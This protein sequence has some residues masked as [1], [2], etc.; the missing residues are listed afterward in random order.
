MKSVPHLEPQRWQRILEHIAD[1]KRK[2]NTSAPQSAILTQTAQGF[3]PRGISKP[4]PRKG[5]ETARFF[6]EE[7]NLI[8][9]ISKPHP[10]KGAETKSSV[11][12]MEFLHSDFKTTSPQGDGN[13]RST[14]NLFCSATII[15]K[16]DPRKG[17][18][19][20]TLTFNVFV[21]VDFKTTSPQGDGNA[22]AYCLSL[23]LALISKPHPR[24]GTETA[25]RAVPWCYQG[26]YFKTTSPQGDGNTQLKPPPCVTG[27]GDR[28][29]VEGAL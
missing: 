20:S 8:L 11:K 6:S 9:K 10:R 25:C 2:E 13:C 24:K 22:R 15:S 18:E 29:A 26:R 19:T 21:R 5:T 1:A 28:E 23:L 14:V 17:T 3:Q 27:E 7:I 12:N 16:P 4:H